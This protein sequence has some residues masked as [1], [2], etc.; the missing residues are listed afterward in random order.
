LSTRPKPVEDLLNL[1]LQNESMSDELVKDA[2]K[3]YGFLLKNYF[4]ELRAMAY[5]LLLSKVRKL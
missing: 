4:D 5:S 3:L 2:F 1:K